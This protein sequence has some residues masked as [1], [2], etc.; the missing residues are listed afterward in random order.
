M[1]AEGFAPLLTLCVREFDGVRAGSCQK[2]DTPPLGESL[3]T[4]ANLF[5]N[6]SF[7]F[8]NI[9]KNI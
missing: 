6:H 5:I 4:P 7:Y 9:Y 3:W 2:P 1:D 8:V